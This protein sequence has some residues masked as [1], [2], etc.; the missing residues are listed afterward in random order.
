MFLS[1]RSF[2]FTIE[3]VLSWVFRFFWGFGGRIASWD[4]GVRVCALDGFGRLN[5]WRKTGF[6]FSGIN[7]LG[8]VLFCFVS[9]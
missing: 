6:G 4:I 5:E 7:C 3:D 8:V 1:F 9:C 2:V